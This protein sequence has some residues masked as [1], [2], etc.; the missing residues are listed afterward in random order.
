MKG[1]HAYFENY[2][3][4]RHGFA[5]VAPWISSIDLKD[6][7]YALSKKD[8]KRMEKKMVAAGDGVAPWAEA[9]RLIGLLNVDPL[10]I[11][12]FEYDF[13]KTNLPETVKDELDVFRRLFA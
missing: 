11:V 13:D 8:P 4:W 5:R 12:H 6:F 10:Y 7:H 3:S 1:P 9:K 2:E